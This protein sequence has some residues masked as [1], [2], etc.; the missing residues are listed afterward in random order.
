VLLV[1]TKLAPSPIEGIGL[2]LD[3]D[4]ESGTVIWEYHAGID[5]VLEASVFPTL[6]AEAGRQVRK[7]SYLDP[8]LDKWVLCGDDARFFN[9]SDFPSCSESGV[10]LTGVTVAARRLLRGEELTTDYRR[11]TAEKLSYVADESCAIEGTD[12]TLSP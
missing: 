11:I 8:V 4:V 6:S 5:L 9:H 1:K 10:G 7:Y 3:E 12:A 2:F